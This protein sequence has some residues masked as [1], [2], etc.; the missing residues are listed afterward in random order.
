MNV[1]TTVVKTC[2]ICGLSYTEAEWNQ[3]PFPR[4]SAD[5]RADF[6]GT[7]L[8]HRQCSCHNTLVRDIT[9]EGQTK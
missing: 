1:E 8:E 4:G 6:D 7:I 9:K 5:G 2:T 3:L